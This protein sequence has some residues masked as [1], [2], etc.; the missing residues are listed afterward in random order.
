MS[1]VVCATRGSFSLRPKPAERREVL[2]GELRQGTSTTGLPSSAAERK[3]S[4]CEG[5][6]SPSALIR[7]TIFFSKRYSQPDESLARAFGRNSLGVL[8]AE[9]IW[10]G[11][12]LHAVSAPNWRL[13][14]RRRDRRLVEEELRRRGLV[15]VDEW[16]ARVD[17]SQFE[18]EADPG[19]NRLP[20]DWNAFRDALTPNFIHRRR[21]RVRQ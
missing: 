16:G 4:R 3:T 2:L 9:R 5:N 14:V 17:Q 19:F 18:K 12:A 13:V 21:A 7:R 1:S 10:Y 15:I 6:A 11:F 20:T 8:S